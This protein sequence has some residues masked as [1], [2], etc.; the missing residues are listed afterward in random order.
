MRRFAG[1]ALGA[2]ALGVGYTQADSIPPL[3]NTA[4]IIEE[5]DA[6]APDFVPSLRFG[7]LVYDTMTYPV[8]G[9]PF[10]NLFRLA[11]NA[12]GCGQGISLTCG[13]GGGATAGTPVTLDSIQFT[14]RAVRDADT[15]NACGSTAP[16]NVTPA[17][18]DCL[19][20]FW[21]DVA[22]ADL[23]NQNPAFTNH[24]GTQAILQVRGNTL[25]RDFPIVSLVGLGIVLD[26]PDFGVTIRYTLPGVG[27]P[28]PSTTDGNLP[29]NCDYGVT[30]L[31]HDITAIGSNGQLSY[32]DG[33][34]ATC[35]PGV[36]DG[37]FQGC[38]VFSFA[39][40]AVANMSLRLTAVAA[41]PGP[42]PVNPGGTCLGSIIDDDARSPVGPIAIDF[43]LAAGQVKWF[44]FVLTQDVVASTGGVP[45]SDYLDL[46]TDGTN[47]VPPAPLSTDTVMTLYVDATGALVAANDDAPNVPTGTNY[48]ALSFGDDVPRLSVP[49]GIIMG[50]DDGGLPKGSYL[51]GLSGYPAETINC[52]W[53]HVSSSTDTG[54]IRLNISANLSNVCAGD[55]NGDR[56]VNESDLGILLGGWQSGACGDLNG[57]GAT[58]EGDLGILL[59]NW[60]NTCP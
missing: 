57:D 24:I 6:T 4:I 14:W 55:L 46:H 20:D 58:S 25:A 38:E 33:L 5:P 31:F 19:I 15:T 30:G 3:A 26:D 37:I 21:D 45:S 52:G 23:N 54:T 41:V 13:P 7:P 10:G 2:L 9:G 17:N 48:S 60:Q 35:G 27:T 44:K 47:L 56:V 8:P 53:R 49:N 18:F 12:P 39:A 40:P 59:A 36:A 42:T 22:P 16:Y 32:G 43:P 29:P 51:V 34:R 1:L 28:F 11:A 50:G